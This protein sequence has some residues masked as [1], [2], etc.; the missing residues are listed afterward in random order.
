MNGDYALNTNIVSPLIAKDSS[1][2]ARLDER[3]KFLVSSIVIGELYFGAQNSTRMAENIVQ[4]ERFMAS[5][6]IIPCD[7]ATAR[8]Y[9][10]VRK[11]LKTVGRPIPENDIW[12]AAISVQHDLTLIT[13]DHH[14]EH[15]QGL[16]LERW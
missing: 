16:K 7:Q 11:A 3:G 2:V 12:I 14:F 10:D 4:L 8:V 6:T 1:A 13:L 5:V 15:V 9:G